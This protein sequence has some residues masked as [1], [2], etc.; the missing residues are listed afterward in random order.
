MKI[1][2]IVQNF[3]KSQFHST[4]LR[5]N[6]YGIPKGLATSIFFVMGLT[7]SVTGVDMSPIILIYP[8]RD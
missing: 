6:N 2:H 7:S 3:K 5:G 4:L 1:I 8:C